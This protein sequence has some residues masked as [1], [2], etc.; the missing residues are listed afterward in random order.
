MI[1]ATCMKTRSFPLISLHPSLHIS[2][3]KDVL[4]LSHALAYIT[5]TSVYTE[6]KSKEVDMRSWNYKDAAF[7]EN[8][9]RMDEIA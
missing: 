7:Y 6:E 3:A 1:L 5:R 2:R 8:Q 4:W 9:I